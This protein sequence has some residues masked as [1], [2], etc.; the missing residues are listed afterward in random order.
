ME[1]LHTYIL[2]TQGQ[3][4]EKFSLSLQQI[5]LLTALFPGLLSLSLRL[6]RFPLLS[7]SSAQPPGLQKEVCAALQKESRN[8]GASGLPMSCWLES[9]LHCSLPTNHA[10][11]QFLPAQNAHWGLYVL[12]PIELLIQFC[13]E[14]LIAALQTAVGEKAHFDVA[15]GAE[16]VSAVVSEEASAQ[17]TAWEA[18]TM[19]T[20]PLHTDNL[21]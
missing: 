5:L 1:K 3:T 7:P 14:A 2:E 16:I 17:I 20:R 6:F 11:A 9:I 4:K 10:R 13:W 12:W 18:R 15:K 19:G 21:D 8:N